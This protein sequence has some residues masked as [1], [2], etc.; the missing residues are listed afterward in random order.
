MRLVEDALLVNLQMIAN[1][2]TTPLEAFILS[3]LEHYVI[4]SSGSE[5]L[6]NGSTKVPKTY[7][8]NRN[9]VDKIS[10]EICFIFTLDS[11]SGE[12]AVNSL[13]Q[14]GWIIENESITT[15]FKFFLPHI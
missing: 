6:H 10:R 13:I 15:N 5:I 8:F 2:G 1:S 11:K 9:L 3:A 7:Y 4:E 12:Q 14:Q